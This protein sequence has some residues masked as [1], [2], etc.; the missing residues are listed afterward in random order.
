MAEEINEKLNA[1]YEILNLFS[2]RDLETQPLENYEIDIYENAKKLVSEARRDSLRNVLH[3][4]DIKQVSKD[5]NILAN[6][7]VESHEDVGRAQ[8]ILQ[9]YGYYTDN[10]DSLY[11]SKTK[12]ARNQMESDVLYH[13]DYFSNFIIEQA[14]GL[15]DNWAD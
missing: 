10:V 11:G 15:F 7:D 3:Q 2:Q 6:M 9:N 14:R 8:K 12:T 13:P 4:T 1:A 5:Y